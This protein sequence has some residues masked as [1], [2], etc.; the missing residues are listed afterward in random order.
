MGVSMFDDVAQGFRQAIAWLYFWS[1]IAKSGTGNYYS[2]VY[3]A[4]SRRG[5]LKTF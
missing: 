4:G 3:F 5:P 1:C 2:I